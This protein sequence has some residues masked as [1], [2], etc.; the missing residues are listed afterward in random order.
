MVNSSAA[1]SLPAEEVEKRTNSFNARRNLLKTSPS[2]YVSK[3]RLSV[4]QIPAGVTEHM[5]K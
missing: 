4:R 5:L 3:T 1:D 2:L